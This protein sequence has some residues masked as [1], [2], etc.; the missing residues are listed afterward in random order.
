L[1]LRTTFKKSHSTWEHGVD[2][3]VLHTSL[4]REQ[5]ERAAKHSKKINRIPRVDKSGMA[6]GYR[7]EWK[8]EL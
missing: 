2:H 7:L 4:S 1:S 6:T 3:L 8:G 5:I